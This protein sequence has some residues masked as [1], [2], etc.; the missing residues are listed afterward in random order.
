LVITVVHLKRIVPDAVATAVGL[1]MA[2]GLALLLRPALAVAS[3]PV[4][5]RGPWFMGG[6]RLMLEYVPARLAGLVFPAL[7]LALLAALPLLSEKRA[8][9]ARVMLLAALVSYAVLTL[10]AGWA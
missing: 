1:G 2:G 5:L 8:R 3:S 4:Q 9:I 6:L 10:V 7:T